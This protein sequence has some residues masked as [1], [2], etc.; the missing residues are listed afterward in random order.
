MN[1]KMLLLLFLGVISVNVQSYESKIEIFEYF[2]DIKLVAF[3]DKS[4]LQNYPSWKPD[5]EVLPLSISQALEAIKDL[6]KTVGKPAL[7]GVVKEIELRVISGYPDYWH[8]LVKVRLNGNK[9]TKYQIYVVLMN[10][11]VIPAMIEPESY[12]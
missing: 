1:Y 11:K 7:D 9:K 2:D 10:G 5:T 12:K 6:H 3:L 8:Y 4:D